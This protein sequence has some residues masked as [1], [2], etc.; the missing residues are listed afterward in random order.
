MRNYSLRN[1]KAKTLKET[2]LLV[3]RAKAG[4][5][6]SESELI[7]EVK[8]QISPVVLSYQKTFNSLGIDADDAVQRLLVKVPAILQNYNE[9]RNDFFAY[10]KTCARNLFNTLCTKRRKVVDA[11]VPIDDGST[12]LGDGG[13]AISDFESEELVNK[14]LSEAKAILKEQEYDALVLF[15]NGYSYEE[16][17]VELGVERKKVDNLLYSA[18]KKIKRNETFFK[19]LLK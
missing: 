10:V 8:A 19:N 5:K 18:R 7:E 11:F 14:F 3:N 16:I 4:D 2:Q 6:R 13:K 9:D 12:A 1:G 15:G 17:A